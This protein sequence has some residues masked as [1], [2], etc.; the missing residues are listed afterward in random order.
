MLWGV[1]QRT[2]A[3]QGLWW[4]WSVQRR[5]CIAGGILYLLLSIGWQVIALWLYISIIAFLFRFSSS[6]LVNYLNQ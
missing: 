1:G 4:H 2:A 3:A 5:P 6:V